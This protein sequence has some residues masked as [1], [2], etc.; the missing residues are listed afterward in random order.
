MLAISERNE[1]NAWINSMYNPQNIE[2]ILKILNL[3][4]CQTLEHSNFKLDKGLETGEMVQCLRVFVEEPSSVPSI[5][6]YLK[7]QLSKGI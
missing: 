7:I 2:R 1:Q 4:N 5:H 3:V 6:N